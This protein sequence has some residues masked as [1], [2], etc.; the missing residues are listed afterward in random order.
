MSISISI[1]K[2]TGKV[3]GRKFFSR[4]GVFGMNQRDEKVSGL[5]NML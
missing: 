3:L 4:C 2:G 1:G 5:F